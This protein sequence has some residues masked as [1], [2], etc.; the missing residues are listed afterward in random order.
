[1]MSFVLTRSPAWLALLGRDMLFPSEPYVSLTT[2]A[3]PDPRVAAAARGDRAAAQSLCAELLPR[4]RN[5]VRYLVRGD[6]DVDDIAQDALIAILRGLGSYRGEGTFKSWVD[7]IVART[8]FAHI[9][10]TRA[11][12]AA[13]SNEAPELL[14]VPGEGQ[15]D[16]YVLRR[17][18]AKMLDALPEE[19]RHVLVLHHAMG[20][21]VPEIAEATGAPFETV[22]SRLRLG[23]A[24][25]RDAME[26]GG[27][28]R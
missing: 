25:L 11:A 1:M 8:T 24:S 2:A 13:L 9:K 10:A 6:S 18:L 26:S 12:G 15:S 7:R 22:R 21:T 17:Q 3:A 14:A 19:Q 27:E 20:M 4:V 16:Q 23:M 5:L 28:K